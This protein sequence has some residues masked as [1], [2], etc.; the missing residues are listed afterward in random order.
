MGGG[1]GGKEA[2]GG[3]DIKQGTPAEK[4]RKEKKRLR[5]WRPCNEKPSIIPA[6][7]KQACMPVCKEQTLSAGTRGAST[8]GQGHTE[9]G[10]VRARKA[11]GKGLVMKRKGSLSLPERQVARHTEK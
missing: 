8:Q 7:D 11:G 5:L 1:G 4:K 10:A 9:T 6:Q 3:G 2:S